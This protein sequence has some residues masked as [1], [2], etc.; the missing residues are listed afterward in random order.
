[1][2]SVLFGGTSILVWVYNITFD[3]KLIIILTITMVYRPCRART[4]IDLHNWTLRKTEMDRKQG[5]PRF[6]RYRGSSPV[7]GYLDNVYNHKL[8]I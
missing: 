7:Y 1:M 8:H 4:L 3:T 5:S 2:V 6:Q